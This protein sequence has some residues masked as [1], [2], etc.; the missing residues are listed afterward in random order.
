MACAAE[1]ERAAAARPGPG[2]L[3]A[4]A[5]LLARARD[6]RLHLLVRPAPPRTPAL[7]LCLPLSAR[8]ASA[9]PALCKFCPSR[10]VTWSWHPACHLLAC[11]CTDKPNAKIWVPGGAEQ[12]VLKRV[13]IPFQPLDVTKI[14][15]PFQQLDIRMS[16]CSG[17]AYWSYPGAEMVDTR[18]STQAVLRLLAWLLGDRPFRAAAA[19]TARSVRRL[20]ALLRAQLGGPS[21]LRRRGHRHEGHAC[22]LLCTEPLKP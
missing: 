8:E 11:S 9:T 20:I 14:A 7:L 2:V 19:V 3:P 16:S 21:A 17:D 18:A 13:C 10:S 22:A 6:Q 15:S 1:R 5:H 4:R 12:R